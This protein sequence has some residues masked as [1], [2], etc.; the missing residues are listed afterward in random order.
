M[1]GGKI[2]TAIPEIV[3]IIVSHIWACL[4][5]NVLGAFTG[6]HFGGVYPQE[7]PSVC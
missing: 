2:M 3:D 6:K 4:L 1:D 7:L 5:F